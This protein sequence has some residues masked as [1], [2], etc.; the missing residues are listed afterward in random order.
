VRTPH[1]RRSK[2]SW[3]RNQGRPRKL[4]G[5]PGTGAG[6]FEKLADG[7]QIPNCSDQRVEHGRSYKHAV[8]AEGLCANAA[9]APVELSSD[10]NTEPDLPSYRVHW[11]LAGGDFENLADGSQIPNYSDQRV[12]RQDLPLRL[13]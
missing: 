6:E 12:G 2:L 8:S 5:V 3:D 9:P 4:S 1:P 7:S 11:T 10:R 13:D